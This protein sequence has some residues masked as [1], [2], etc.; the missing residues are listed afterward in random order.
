MANECLG[1]HVEQQRGGERRGGRCG[2]DSEAA[3][4]RA[5]KE[6]GRVRVEP[7]CGNARWREAS[8]AS[9][10]ALDRFDRPV[11]DGLKVMDRGGDIGVDFKDLPEEKGLEFWRDLYFK[12]N[13]AALNAW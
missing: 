9:P 4:P 1:F 13:D 3:L 5:P 10:F 12:L 8:K 11:D 7:V 2:L 6:T